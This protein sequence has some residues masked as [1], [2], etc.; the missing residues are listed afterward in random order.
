MAEELYNDDILGIT[1]RIDRFL[2]EIN[3]SQSANLSEYHAADL[4]RL[5]SYLSNLTV[6]V[7]WVVGQPQLDLPETSPL[8]LEIP[9][10]P[11]MPEADNPMVKDII[12]LVVRM[13]GEILRSQSARRSTGLVKFDEERMRA[14][15]AKCENYL[16][17]YVEAVN[18]IDLPE[19][20]PDVPVTG[21]GK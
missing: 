20:S 7:D 15:I 5:K 18:P 13:R 8:S 1:D 19:S 2:Q 11:D 16:E 10:L 6:Y 9:A 17:A 14:V 21:P 3:K 4:G 12:R